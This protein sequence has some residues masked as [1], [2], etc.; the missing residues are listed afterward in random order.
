MFPYPQAGSA[1][2][3]LGSVLGEP[4]QDEAKQSWDFVLS[5]SPPLPGSS[6]PWEEPRA[7]ALCMF[8]YI[9]GSHPFAALLGE[10]AS[11]GQ[12]VKQTTPPKKKSIFGYSAVVRLAN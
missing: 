4:G 2:T 5:P 8:L 3:R 7:E 10:V 6:F 11:V 9:P 1:P 12:S